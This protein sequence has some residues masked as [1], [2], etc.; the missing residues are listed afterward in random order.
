MMKKHILLLVSI[1]LIS[2]SKNDEEVEIPTAIESKFR[3][4][5][6]QSSFGLLSYTYNADGNLTKRIA[7]GQF[8]QGTSK[9]YT[10]SNKQLTT[11]ESETFKTTYSYLSNGKIDEII[12]QDK[13][14]R[15]SYFTKY[16][17]DSQGNLYSATHSSANS[18]VG[19]LKLNYIAY[20]TF[21]SNKIQV[22]TVAYNN[23]NEFYYIDTKGNISKIERMTTNASGVTYKSFEQINIYD[24]KYNTEAVLPYPL[25]HFGTNIRS[26]NNVLYQIIKTYDENGTVLS[27]SADEN[28]YEYNSDGYVTKKNEVIYTLEKQ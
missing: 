22:N 19:P 20:Y 7:A 26:K 23:S 17:Y 18:M 8:T 5:K 13:V 1:L 11:V 15:K 27:T 9:D 14:L 24:D 16:A 25:E 4:I 3:L 10:Y 28:S 2:C 21:W 6:S 12:E